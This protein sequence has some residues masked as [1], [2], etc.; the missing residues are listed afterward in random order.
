MPTDLPDLPFRKGAF[1][2]MIRVFSC[3]LWASLLFVSQ[4]VLADAIMVSKA[5]QSDTIAQFYVDE[6]GIR[7]ETE[8]G[9]ESLERFQNLL[10]DA[11]YERLGL[12]PKPLRERLRLFFEQDFGVLVDGKPLPGFVT[13]MGPARRVL[14][15]QI[16]GVPL[17]SQ[18]EAPQVIKAQFVFPFAEG[19]PPERL[20]FIAPPRST[21]GFVVYHN[22]VAVNDY[23]YL[24]SGYN[25]DLD[26]QDPWYS[27][28]DII[29]LKRR[30]LES[31]SG[32]LYVEHF[33]VRKEII[34]RPK[35]LQRW[36]DLGL[37]DTDVIKADQRGLVLERIADFLKDKQP[38]KINGEPA[39]PLLD[40][41]NFLNR[42]LKKSM[43]VE[44]GIDIDLDGAVV[45]AIFVYPT[46]KLADSAEMTWDLFDDRVQRVPASSVDEAG[47]L[48]AYLE[49]DTPVL[50]WTNYLKNPSDPG[51]IELQAPSSALSVLLYQA[52]WWVLGVALLLVVIWGRQ[53]SGALGAL[54]AIVLVVTGASFVI[55][56][57]LA[58][59]GEAGEQVVADLL[60]NVYKAFDYREESDIYDVLDRSVSG[61]LLTEI[62][63]ETQR[64]LELAN[65]GGARAKV[66][67][68][69]IQ[70]LDLSSGDQAGVI[71]ADA[72]WNVNGSV[73]HW[74]HVHTRV[75]QYQA[76][77]FIEA[78][79]GRWKL[80][81]M[82]VLQEQRL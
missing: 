24:Q 79:D 65:Q 41:I 66:K 74:G 42:T 10:P 14:R 11:L 50:Q 19:A 29:Q 27:S 78:V 68:I 48:P 81:D 69:D 1:P 31:M 56:R 54:T 47:P 61:D 58:P 15:D 16:T 36:V 63:L 40:R 20:T 8:I 18:D 6:E 55:G 39:T 49:P 77:L 2:Q 60:R 71:K 26:W 72:T 82:N 52:R 33:E 43:V 45:G 12:P 32:F 22:G 37:A 70:T 53:R 28:F 21:I 51:L 23:R 57:P 9:L 25:L 62:Y 17:A 34:V 5:L 64:G 80:V 30:Y 67:S 46:S 75:N 44:P 76:E 59:P 35:D 4:S 73:G 3:L 7:V 38:V 13:E